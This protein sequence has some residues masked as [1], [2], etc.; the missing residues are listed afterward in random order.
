MEWKDKSKEAIELIKKMITDQHTRLFT[1]QVL[2]DPWMGMSKIKIVFKEKIK[3][4]FH[5]MK[6]FS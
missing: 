6:K 5:N 4:L 3:I 2:S 1:D